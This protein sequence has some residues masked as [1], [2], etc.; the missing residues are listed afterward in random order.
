MMHSSVRLTVVLPTLLGSLPK[1]PVC[2]FP[3][4]SLLV[5]SC[6][7]A[8][9]IVSESKQGHLLIIVYGICCLSSQRLKLMRI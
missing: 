9:M 7:T 3:L 6:G 4:K 8:V 5:S 2:Y 1:P